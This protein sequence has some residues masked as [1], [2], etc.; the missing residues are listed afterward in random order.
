ME[1]I[2]VIIFGITIFLLLCYLFLVRQELKRIRKEMHLIKT[3]QTNTLLHTEVPF[4][5]MKS[6]VKEINESFYEIR[7]K[8]S[9]LEHKNQRFMKMMRNISH[10]LRTPLTSACGYL[11]LILK[12]NMSEEDKM[13]E[14]MIVQNRMQRLTE[15]V[16]SFFE[17]S[18]MVTSNEEIELNQE[19][20]VGLMEECIGM[21][22]E[23]YKKQNREI[24]FEASNHKI[25]LYTNRT[26]LKRVFEN[27]IGNAFKHGS[28]NLKIEIKKEKNVQIRFV[29]EITDDELDVS[30]M[31]DEFYTTD[32]SRTKGSTGLGLAI[33]KEFTR[34]LGGSV[35]AKKRCRVLEIVIE[36]S[37]VVSYNH[38]GKNMK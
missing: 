28:G 35:V 12:S 37:S 25:R 22:Y 30:K 26:M 14:L 3:N 2:I 17:F 20:I 32:I 10:D 21:F 9:E 15:L 18:K 29:N 33:V 6:I 23:D 8:E 31:F 24:D 4:S 34:Q 11:D 7:K 1:I 16:N 27:L 36:L 38:F 5:V 13:K 19:N